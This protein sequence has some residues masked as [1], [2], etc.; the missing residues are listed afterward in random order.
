MSSTYFSRGG[1]TLYQGDNIDVLS[2]L[3]NQSVHLVITSPP[4]GELRDYEGFIHSPDIVLRE[5]YR[6]L[7]E[8]GIVVW[9]ENDQYIDGSRSLETWRRLI[10]AKDVIGFRVS[11]IMPWVKQGIQLVASNRYSQCWEPMLILSKG[12]PQTVNKIKD[13]PNQYAGKKLAKGSIGADADGRRTYTNEN[14]VIQPLGER[15]N[16]WRL[17]VG[18]HSTSPDM[19]GGK[20]LHPAPFPLQLA[21]DH[22]I[23]WTN[24]GDVVL[25]PYCGSGTTMKAAQNTGRK[26]IGIEISSKYCQMI[27]RRMA[28]QSLL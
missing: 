17:P 20:T 27:D 11:D 26:S 18:G 3:P 19:P 7:V 15:T 9:V 14:R 24:E 6:I 13:V 1:H 4:Y 21:I 23:S 2:E 10:Y 8:G 25:D 5:C 12:V 28:Q 16:V 22:I